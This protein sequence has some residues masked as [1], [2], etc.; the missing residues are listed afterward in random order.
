V[1]NDVAGAS[2]IARLTST[3]INVARRRPFTWFLGESRSGQMTRAAIFSLGKATLV[4]AVAAL[5]ACGTI[6]ALAAEGT[7]A[8]ARAGEELALGLCSNCHVVAPNQSTP[9]VLDHPP[10]TFQQ[11]AD[12]PSTTA[13]GVHRFI[14]TTH[15]DYWSLPMTMPDPIL[16]DEE[17]DQVSAYILSLRQGPAP[18]PA[19]EARLTR[20]EVHVQKGEYLALKLC[21]YCHVV[22]S[23]ARYRPALDQ[24]TPS[25]QDIAN[26]PKTTA[27]SLRRFMSTTHWDEK[28][29][30]MTMPDPELEPDQTTD[31][32]QYVLALRKPR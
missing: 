28:T 3:S 5:L 6:R 29:I 22:S 26:D 20:S 12:D 27:A 16:L 10:K 17:A 31:L 9:P 14:T 2:R 4:G 21:S 1:V 15:W 7:Q 13:A 32:I 19:P 23:D 30:P 25:F 18:S 11:I 24:R 8:K